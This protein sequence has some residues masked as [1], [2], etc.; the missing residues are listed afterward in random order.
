MTFIKT[1][2]KHGNKE[3]RCLVLADAVDAKVFQLRALSYTSLLGLRRKDN[4][5]TEGTIVNRRQQTV[6]RPVPLAAASRALLKLFLNHT[7]RF[8]GGR[9]CIRVEKCNRI[10]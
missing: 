10:R 9:V 1:A 7:L 6:W 2:S 3:Q 5:K 4:S 8:V